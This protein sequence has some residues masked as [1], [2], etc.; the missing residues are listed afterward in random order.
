[1]GSDARLHHVV[2]ASGHLSLRRGTILLS[3]S[4]NFRVHVANPAP[5]LVG[6]LSA[7]LRIVNVTTGAACL[8]MCGC[9]K[10]ARFKPTVVTGTLLEVAGFIPA[11]RPSCIGPV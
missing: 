4:R 9:V 1:M 3:L 10:H 2:S 6:C 11:S 8:P 7:M 5:K